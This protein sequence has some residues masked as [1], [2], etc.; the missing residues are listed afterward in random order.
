MS[1]YQLLEN[2]AKNPFDSESKIQKSFCNQEDP[3]KI[4]DLLIRTELT[5]EEGVEGS[6]LACETK[7]VCW[8]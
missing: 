2:L 5:R 6:L 1:L 8:E 7:V 4:S 3:N